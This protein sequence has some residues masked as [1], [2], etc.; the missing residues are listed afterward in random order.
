[1]V[2]GAGQPIRLGN[3]LGQGG[4]GSVYELPA[5]PGIVAK[6]YH[7]PPKPVIADKIRTMAALRT[8]QIDR[9][10]AWPLDVVRLRSGAPVGLTM[11]QVTGCKDIHRLFSPKSRRRE[12]PQADWRFLVRAAAN[13]ARAF[14]MVHETSSVIAD[15]NQG[16]VLVGQD[17]RIR[18]ID[19]DSFQV[20]DGGKRYLC[21]VGVATFTP[22][23]LQGR[24]FAELVRTANHDNFGL[25]VLVFLI[26]FMGRHPFA[27]RHLGIGE[28]TI[29][30]AIGDGRFPYG[31]HALGAQMERP[32][33][34]PPLGIVS[35]PVARLF[36]RAFAREAPT[37]GRPTAQQ[38]VDA[39][40]TLERN[41]R[42]CSASAMHW[43]H[44]GLI[45]CPWCQMEAATGV[46]LFS[47]SLSAA[48]AAYFDPDS[49][50]PQVSTLP[51]PGSPPPLEDAVPNKRKI[52]PSV[53][54]ISFKR[55]YWFHVPLALFIAGIP[56]AAGVLAQ[57]PDL[58]RIF[59][60]ASALILYFL[61]RRALKATINIS[62]FLER[63]RQ[64]RARWDS[65]GSEWEAKAG[66]RRFEDKRAELERLW[67][68]WTSLA[69]R[70]AAK[71][72]EIGDRKRDIQLARHL[73]RFELAAADIPGVGTGRKSLLQSFG[74][75]TAADVSEAR[76]QAI[77]GFDVRLQSS[78]LTW[79]R[80]LEAKFTFDPAGN[81][82]EQDRQAIEQEI[83]A[84]RLR[85]GLSI[86]TGFGELQQIERQIQFARSHLRPRGE[87][88]YR[89]YLQAEADLKAVSR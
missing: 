81:S 49:F 75:E 51:H 22:P 84:E 71:L 9:L 19:C 53:E 31:E 23:E 16:G 32:P 37:K 36:E 28:M 66:P 25:A 8:D 55:R 67:T 76:L 4:E 69:A 11:P 47:S 26:L 54:A 61:V 44:A 5:S 7:R 82:D 40:E 29:E 38:W 74:M 60:F 3:K 35:E 14:A 43:H 59:F 17:A 2:D 34:A 42:Q 52:R 83:L 50:W 77:P 10:A 65:I 63:D 21:E 87:E 85:I 80:A 6:I 39:L 20:T 86:R 70:R 73:D 30:H 58:G 13:L 18:L 78:V 41:L 62:T 57:V 89:A 24:P 1:L 45:A 88:A 48:T 46:P 68:A 12:F 56:V 15:V 33:G 64:Q 27:G 79:R 72:D